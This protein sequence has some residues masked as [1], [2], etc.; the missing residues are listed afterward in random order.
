MYQ[1]SDSAKAA[2]FY[3]ERPGLPQEVYSG[4]IGNN[5]KDLQIM[6]A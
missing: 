1:V 6:V 3:R 5:D 4:Q 2:A